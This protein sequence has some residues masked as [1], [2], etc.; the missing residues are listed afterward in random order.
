MK[1]A[2]SLE[3]RKS[4]ARASR[5]R[6]AQSPRKRRTRRDWRDVD[7]D[8]EDAPWEAME[9]MRPASS[10]TNEG[11]RDRSP[12]IPQRPHP[13]RIVAVHAGR[14]E[15]ARENKRRSA[16]LGG[17]RLAAGPP[18]VGDWAA[19]EELP[20]GECRLASLAERR[21]G[22]SRHWPGQRRATQWL[23]ANVDLGL[24]A[25]P[26]QEDGSLRLG[27]IERLRIAYREGGIEPLL[28]VTKIDRLD[29][30]A[31]ERLADVQRD[32]QATHLPCYLTSAL[33]G[34]GLAELAERLQG[35]AVVVAGH[36]GVGKSTLLNAL[37]PEFERDTGGVRISDDRGRHT[38]TASRMT[39][40]RGGWLIDT[41]G[42]RS[43]GLHER[44]LEQWL[45]HF[46]LL[47]E[48]AEDC[49]K[50]C[51]HAQPDCALRIQVAEE[52]SADT[53]LQREWR[54]L[55]RLLQD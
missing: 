37:D 38:T 31:R 2:K 9:S 25:L 43:F 8:S 22:L 44:P 4:A 35:C 40:F 42:I 52:R 1:K 14:V 49:P 45:E 47:E 28:V 20:G 55:Q 32:L 46:P 11:R 33:D 10:S 17:A 6:K 27:L 39:P 50:G 7:D 29:A 54:S 36:S 3:E 15:I 19:I 30:A 12:A 48:L 24:I 16:H 23:A 21:S 5:A 26:A 51:R 34:T 53:P 13:W 18:V 41:P